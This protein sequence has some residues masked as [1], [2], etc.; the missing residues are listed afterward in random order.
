MVLFE[1]DNI[2]KD[3]YYKYVE[4]NNND[5][6]EILNFDEFKYNGYIQFSKIFPFYFS[7]VSKNY[8]ENV[9]YSDKTHIIVSC[10]GD[11]FDIKNITSI[12]IFH[13][14]KSSNLTKYYVLLLGTHERFRKYGYGKVILDEFI[15]FVKKSN[16]SEKKIKILLKSLET[17]I[18]FYLSN[19]FV[20]TQSELKSNRLFYKYETTDELK[21]NQEKILE[22]DII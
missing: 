8:I 16:K 10:I 13:K 21:L 15:E 2:I 7:G 20:Q 9:L 3:K 6:N 19:G 17:S 14:T 1:F 11:K 12:L 22:L 4:K 18:Q 5:N